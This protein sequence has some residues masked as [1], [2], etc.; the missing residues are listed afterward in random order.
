[1]SAS[2]AVDGATLRLDIQ[3]LP[4]PWRAKRFDFPA[5]DPGVVDHAGPTA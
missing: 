5:A 1:V 4:A 3:G 2:A